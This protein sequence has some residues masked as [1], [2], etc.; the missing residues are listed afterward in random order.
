VP[1]VKG[2]TA[3]VLADVVGIRD[4]TGRA[5]SVALGIVQRVI[6]EQLDLGSNPNVGIQ[7]E[8]ILLEIAL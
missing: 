1:N 5:G 3:I 8:L 6:A 7:N 2:A 4:E